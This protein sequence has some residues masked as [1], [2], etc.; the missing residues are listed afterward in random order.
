MVHFTLQK[1]FVNSAPNL[2][3]ASQDVGFLFTNIPLDATID[4]CIE[5]LYNDNESPHNIPKH[6]FRNLI[7]IA[8]K[9]PYL[10]FKNKY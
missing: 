7:S 9:E 8:T 4:I 3:L 2:H 10:T 5:N 6:D 1:K